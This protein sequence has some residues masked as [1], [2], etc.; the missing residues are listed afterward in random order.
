MWS[1]LKWIII[2]AFVACFIIFPFFRCVCTH[3]VSVTRYGSVDLFKYFK[4]HMWNLC[5]EGDVLGKVRMYT[6]LTDKVFGCGKTL[7]MV[8]EIC[9]IYDRYNNKLVFDT[10]RNI[11][12]RQRVVV[13]T[14]VDI[15]HMNTIKLES[16]KQ[17]TDYAKQFYEYDNENN[18]RT[19]LIVAIDEIGVM[20]NSRAFKTNIDPMFLNTLLTCRKYHIAIYCTAQRFSMVDAL[21]RS[22]TQEVVCCKKIWRLQGLYVYDGYELENCTN[23]LLVQPKGRTCKFISNKDYNNYDTHAMVEQLELH[24]AK[25]EMLTEEEILQR[26]APVSTDTVTKYSKVAKKRRPSK[27]S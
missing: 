25:G 2:I 16:L 9:W 7:S 11:W 26:L 8:K 3:P 15:N 12:V 23:P 27:K 6:A 21:F 14:N 19:C 1:I 17:V 10:K 22:I 4:Y 5:P 24:Q 20:L 13:L 18:T